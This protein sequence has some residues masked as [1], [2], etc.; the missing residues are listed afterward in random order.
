MFTIML[1]RLDAK[2]IRSRRIWPRPTAVTVGNTEPSPNP[3]KKIGHSTALMVTHRLQDAFVMASHYFDKQ[4]NQM[5]PT[6]PGA[7]A[8]VNTTFLIMKDARV[9]F[10][11]TALELANSRDEY[12]K[13]YIA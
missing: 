11:G 7:S 8:E 13:E 1:N 10:D 2:P 12:I 6:P 4:A 9:I 3:K 5:K